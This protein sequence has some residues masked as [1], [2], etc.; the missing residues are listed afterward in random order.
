MTDRVQVR[1]NVDGGWLVIENNRVVAV[2][3]THQRAIRHAQHIARY[4]VSKWSVPADRRRR[5]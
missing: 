1:Q 2:L 4:G 3:P 5:R